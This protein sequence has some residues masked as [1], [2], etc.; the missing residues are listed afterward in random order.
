MLAGIYYGAQYGGS[1]TAILVNLPGEAS[2]VVTMLDGYPMARQGRA[3]PALAIAAIGSFFAGCIGTLVIA[4]FAP[5]AR[6]D[7]AEVRLA[8]IFLADGVGAGL[9]CGAGA[10]VAAQV[11]RDGGARPAARDRRHRRQFGH[12]AFHL[13]RSGADG[14]H[15]LR[16]RGHGMFA[17]A[18]IVTNLEQRGRARHDPQAIRNRIRLCRRWEDFRSPSGRSC[19]ALASARSSG[20]LP[21]G[22]A[23]AASFTSYT[24]EKKLAKDPSRF[25]K[26]AIEG[27][28]GPEAPTTPV[29]RRRS[30][31]C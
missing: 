16:R 26:G 5:A 28:A 31:R 23:T 29:R 24:V 14:R 8:G 25:G 10:R 20:M 21:G 30:F 13:R 4:L 6:R 3:G 18:E 19:A 27:V 12:V 1:T 9:R 22:G 15:R 7:R 17:V 11:A 2:S